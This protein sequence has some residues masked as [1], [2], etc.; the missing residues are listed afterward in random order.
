MIAIWIETSRFCAKE[1]L[2]DLE[3][4][5]KEGKKKAILAATLSV[6][7]GFLSVPEAALGTKSIA[8][9]KLKNGLGSIGTGQANT[10][11]K[12]I[13]AQGGPK[14]ALIPLIRKLSEISDKTATLEYLALLSKAASVLKSVAELGASDNSL[15][16]ANDISLEEAEARSRGTLSAKANDT[17][18]VGSNSTDT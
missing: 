11:I 6:L 4:N 10:I 5:A 13:R 18:F 14:Q 7:D 9:Y 17:M 16:A 2:E 8:E 3:T 12:K 1:D 15:D